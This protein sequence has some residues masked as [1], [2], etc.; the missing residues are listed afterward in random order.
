MVNAL[1][2]VGF[3]NNKIEIA[4]DPKRIAIKE[5]R[6]IALKI[7]E[8][9]KS[10]VL[11]KTNITMKIDAVPTKAVKATPGNIASKIHVIVPYN[12]PCPIE[13]TI[14]IGAAIFG[15]NIASIAAINVIIPE[16]ANTPVSNSPGRNTD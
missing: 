15:I 13:Y 1:A 7:L 3:T 16:N 5:P 9:L 6:T 2:K 4:N 8:P 12:K 14:D 11:Y 10:P